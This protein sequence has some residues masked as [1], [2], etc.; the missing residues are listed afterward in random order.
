MKGIRSLT[1]ALCGGLMLVGRVASGQVPSPG[2]R[3]P[4]GRVYA[5][6]VVTITGESGAFGH[7]VSG[8]RF[9]VVSENGDR[10]SIRTDDAGVASAW[11]FP[12]SYRLVTP[13]PYEWDGNAYTW[14]AV[15]A[16]RPGAWTIWLSQAYASLIVALCGVFY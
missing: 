12:G 11:V 14:D 13:D 4:G 9:L 3:D 10:V 2:D 7:A 8:L 15:V 1:V 6:V 5:K 16:I